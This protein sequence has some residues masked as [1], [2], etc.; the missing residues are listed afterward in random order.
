MA[1]PVRY[2]PEVGDIVWIELS[3]TKGRE[4]AGHRPAIV[5]TKASFND[6]SNL[7]LCVPM[8]SQIKN[9]P[10]EVKVG[11]GAALVD[12]T[13]S[14]DWKARN[15]THKGRATADE[16]EAVRSKLRKLIG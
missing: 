11:S 13:R 15:M 7:M 16:I 10:F 5:L 2:I 3:P 12:Q 6:R 14:V 9:Y 8:T 4:Q 1:R